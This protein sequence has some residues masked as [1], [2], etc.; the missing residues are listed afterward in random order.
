MN[1][2][3]KTAKELNKTLDCFITINDRFSE[4]KKG[5]LSKYTISVKD[6]FCTKGLRTTG[7]SR[8]LE[9]YIPTYDAT[10]VEKV[11]KLGGAII[12]KTGM[13]EFGF[14]TFSTNCG[15]KIPKNPWDMNRTCGGSSGGSGCITAAIDTP[16]IA[17][18]EST[19]GSISA[20]AAFCGVVGITPTYGRVSRYGLLSYAS[21]LDKPG[22]IAQNVK[23]A[24]LG[25]SIIAGHDERDSTSINK[26]VPD[27]VKACKT[28][29]KGIKIGIPKEYLSEGVDEKVKEHFHNAVAKLEELGAKTVEVSLPMTKYALSTYYIIAVSEASTNLAK[30]CGIRYGATLPIKGNYDEFFSEVRTKYFGDEA[31]RRIIL[32]TFTRMTGYRDAYYLKAMKV[33]RLIIED[34]KKAFKKVDVL[35]T[36]TMPVV[37]PRFDEIQKLTPMQNWAM[38]VC[39]VGPNLAGIPMISVPCGFADDMPVGLHILGDHLDE[40]KLFHVAYAYENACSWKTRR[41]KI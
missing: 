27:Y 14:G 36:P 12:G 18:A 28:D 5:E 17:V 23:D 33:R 40:S 41:P 32:G 8:I 6:C 39:T 30:Y 34:F 2:I 21:S 1:D 26:E 11:K 22:I 24:A 25:L 35:V 13:D 15:Y 31:K 20:P 9:N 19:G 7:G 29:L 10:V 3:I 4:S 16:H 38:D 37:A